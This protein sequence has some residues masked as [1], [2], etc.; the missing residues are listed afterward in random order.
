MNTETFKQLQF[1]KIQ[2]E[3][4]K[5]AIGDLTKEKIAHLAPQSNLATVTVWQKETQEARLMIDSGQHV[6]FMGLVR[7]NQLNQQIKKGLILN[8]AELTEVA[9]FL[10]SSQLMVKFFDKNRYQA[11]T[12]ASYSQ[13]LPDFS[14]MTETI[15]QKI[16][17]HK[18]S[19]E[20]SRFLRKTRRQK[21]ET[22]SEIQEKLNKYLRHPNNKNW[23]QDSIIV[24]KGEHFT[25]PIKASYKNKVDGTVIEESGKGQT[26][27]VEPSTVSKLNEKLSF[28]IADE[29]AEEYQIL[30]EL[31][32][33]LAENQDLIDFTIESISGFDLIFAR[34]K[35]SRE[36]NGITPKVNKNEVIK[37]IAG[38]HP[39]LSQEAVPLDFELGE[40]YRGLVITGANA[41]GKTVVLKTVGLF[42]LMAMFGLQIPAAE[43]SEIAVLNDLFV[44]IGDQQNLENALSTFSGHMKNIA[45]ILRQAKRHSLVLLDEIG[46][47]TEPNEGAALAIAIMETLYQ[48]GVLIVATTHYGEIKR[49]A[50]THEDFVPAAMAFDRENLTPKYRLQVGKT[51]DSQALW[52]AKK[53]HMAP[54]LIQQAANYISDKNYLTEKKIFHSVK[55][56]SQIEKRSEERFNQGDQVILT[57]TNQVGLVYQDEG[58]AEVTVYL[59]KEMIPILR[60]RLK[61]KMTAQELYPA[62]YDLSSLFVDFHERKREKDLARGSKKA[63]KE[64]DKEMR[65]RR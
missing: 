56:T 18:V 24:K 3:V 33:A 10:R 4:Q 13:N 44:D 12:L 39:F 48:S 61:L 2:T 42:S 47:G 54:A 45:E 63:H 62:D 36:M 32:G 51:G 50:E 14:S 65:L 29:V 38:K 7:I 31:T 49:F 35:Y 64:L 25:I 59:E 23:I 20:A 46:S 22:E 37:I 8:P 19:S 41:G 43:G 28:L 57:E 53:M 26:V 27:F 52:I 17:H 58:K 15:Y 1:D 9:D 55:E 21:S 34:G 60:K 30:A 16:Q 5:R 40:N 11:P 6:P